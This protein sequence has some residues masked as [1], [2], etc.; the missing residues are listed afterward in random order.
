MSSTPNEEDPSSSRA[1]LDG[2][3]EN[4]TLDADATSGFSGED[5]EGVLEPAGE[6]SMADQLD[7]ARGEAAENYER[8]VRAR[9]DIE[10]IL[11]RHQREMS[12]R[13]RYDGEG[14]ARDILPA[15][16]DLERALQHADATAGSVSSGVELV[17]K[18]L[19]AALQRN[20]VEKIE[21]AGK[22]FDPAEHEAVTMVAADDVPP[23]TVMEVFRQGYKIRDR[24]LRPAMVSVS[25]AGEGGAKATGEAVEQ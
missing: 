21:A 6:P 9:A 14:L 23:G 20:G 1:G 10:N 12:D 8:F 7:E 15:I 3:D 22:P 2:S 25:K 5:T 18:G 17:L 4:P 24:L 16:D 11:K 19:L 13:A